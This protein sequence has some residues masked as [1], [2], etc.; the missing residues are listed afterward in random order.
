MNLL[1]VNQSIIDMFASFFTLLT[2]NVEVGGAGMSRDNTRDQFICRIWL[3][4]LPLWNFLIMSTYCMF[5]TALERYI[6]VV[7]PIWYSNN[8]RTASVALVLVQQ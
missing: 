4:R 8:V 1:I 6:A 5:L 2:A 7:Y 3:A